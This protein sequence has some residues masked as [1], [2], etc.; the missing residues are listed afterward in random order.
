MR[1]TW[2]IHSFDVD[3][4]GIPSECL[5]FQRC[6]AAILV[7]VTLRRKTSSLKAPW[8]SRKGICAAGRRSNLRGSWRVLALAALFALPLCV[9]ACGNQT[10]STVSARAIEVSSELAP[11]QIIN[12]HVEGDPRT[13]DPSLATD[14]VGSRVLDDLFEGLVTL[15]QQ[16]HTI[17]GVAASWETSADG[18]T[19]TFQL[20][21]NARWANGQPVT[22]NDFVYSWRRQVDP[23]TGSE[24]AQALAPIENAMDAAAGKMPPS[25]LGVESAGPHTLVVHL[26]TPTAYLLALLTNAYLYP[27]YEPAVK[28]WSDDWTQPG[29]LISNG[30]FQLTERV[31]NGVS[32]ST[33]IPIIGM[34]ATCG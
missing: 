26:R 16:G 10:P 2:R 21:E 30:A 3:M 15:D 18:K 11:E 33:K 34:P 28:Q 20:R 25:K 31:I 7:V 1:A 19:W 23:A 8:I 4:D 27:I 6:A 12:R 9:I 17:P 32:R 13:L 22:A 5:D 24:Y 14:V 29:H